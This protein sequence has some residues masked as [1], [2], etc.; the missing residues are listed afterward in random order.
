MIKKKLKNKHIDNF[1]RVILAD[2]KMAEAEVTLRMAMALIEGKHV[3]SDVVVAIDGAQVKTLKTVHFPIVEFLASQGWQGMGN[4][5]WQGRYENKN[6]SKAITVHSLPGEGDLVARIH[7]GLN[8][9]MESKKGPLT[10]SKSSQEYRLIR[11]AIGQL[12]TVKKAEPTDILAVLVP[13]S[14]KFSSLA[15]QWRERPLMKKAGIH[16]VTID[17]SNK[18]RGL[19]SLGI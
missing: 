7:S 13:H 10:R 5:G 11:E 3:S 6:Y 1:R 8:L 19:E 16:I 18:I 17:R 9:R 15:D 14:E 2:D 12:M 4:P